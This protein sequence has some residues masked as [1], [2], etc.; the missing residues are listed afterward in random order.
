MEDPSAQVES[1]QATQPT[2]GANMKR[3]DI[4]AR[5]AQVENQLIAEQARSNEMQMQI[6]EGI[7]VQGLQAQQNNDLNQRLQQETDQL[8]RVSSSRGAGLTDQGVLDP[9]V[10][11]RPNLFC[12]S[13]AT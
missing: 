6:Q 8:V 11:L 12:G 1:P 5:L 3:A 10:L 13:R 9:K 2:P 7:R 4:L